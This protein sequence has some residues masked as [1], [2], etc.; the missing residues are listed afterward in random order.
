MGSSDVV[1]NTDIS[2]TVMHVRNPA[3]FVTSNYKVGHTDK[4]GNYYAYNQAF[5]TGTPTALGSNINIR[6]VMRNDSSDTTT[7]EYKLFSSS[8]TTLSS[9][10]PC[11]PHHQPLAQSYNPME[12]DLWIC[13]EKDLYSCST[14]FNDDSDSATIKTE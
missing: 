14:T 2:I 6:E 13:D 7:M 1:A 10:T 11:H 12:Y 3:A 8:L 5:G 4:D 9:S